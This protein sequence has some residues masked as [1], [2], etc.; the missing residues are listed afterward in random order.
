[1]AMKCFER[2]VLKCLI[3]PIKELVDPHQ[4]AY[5]PKKSVQDAVLYLTH[6]HYK[7]TDAAKCYARTLFVDF[8]SAFNTI[9]P[10]RL[11]DKLIRLEVKPSL[12]LWITDFLKNRIQRVR[13]QNVVSEPI[14]TNTG[15]PQGC[16]L[17][18]ILFIL[19]TNDCR[20]LSQNVSIVKYADDTVIVS[21]I[22]ECET[23]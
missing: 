8:S 10:H 4:Y 21:L 5:Q 11:I 20:Y 12:I 18:A 2:I 7:H 1:M 14:L 22:K 15:S 3:E 19:Y 13:V 6:L 17:S 9:Q 23:N 16:V